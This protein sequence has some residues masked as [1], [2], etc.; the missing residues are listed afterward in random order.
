MCVCLM[1]KSLFLNYYFFFREGR[2]RSAEADVG[3]DLTIP[4]LFSIKLL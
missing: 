4:R 3:F 1:F 2:L